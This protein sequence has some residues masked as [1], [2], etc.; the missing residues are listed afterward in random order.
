MK[1][2]FQY[3]GGFFRFMDKL[4]SIFWLNLLCLI[5]CIPIFTIGA[6]I[7]ACYYV[8]LKMVR[9][10]ECYIT[11]EFFRSFK[12][13]FRQATGIWLIF[14]VIGLLFFTDYRLLNVMK[15][16]GSAAVPFGNFIFI[17]ICAVMIVCI[18]ILTYVFPVLAKF[19]NSIKN[20]IRNAFVLSIRHLP[21]T[22]ALILINALFPGVLV[23]VLWFGK[24]LWL[25]PV[26]LCLGTAGAA[27]FC[28]YLFVK[29][30]DLYVPKNETA[31]EDQNEDAEEETQETETN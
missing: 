13:N 11:K 27:Y 31:E 19:D 29:I 20:T 30:F 21:Q 6:S 3:E 23:L 28:S 25:I 15:P 10:E 4:G 5:C 1:E 8:T 9:D 17:V 12:L 24:A 16:D 2:F 7:T 22:A 26:I 14:S 18:M